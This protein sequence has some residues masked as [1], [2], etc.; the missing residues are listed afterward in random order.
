MPDRTR[1]LTLRS[2]DDMEFSL[3]STTISV[4]SPQSISSSLIRPRGPDCT[5]TLIIAVRLCTAATKGATGDGTLVAVSRGPAMRWRWR[6]DM[7]PYLDLAL[8]TTSYVLFPSGCEQANGTMHSR[9]PRGQLSLPSMV[10]RPNQNHPHGGTTTVGR[11]ARYVILVNHTVLGLLTMSTYDIPDAT[12]AESCSGLGDP[13]R[14]ITDSSQS[15]N[16]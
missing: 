13:G 9:H 12:F 3:A 10:A 11:V 5:H 2:I 6:C 1:W 8:G 14:R 16:N 4:A 15:P 7:I